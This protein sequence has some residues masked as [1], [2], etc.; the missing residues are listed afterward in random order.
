MCVWLTVFC[1]SITG[2]LT[3]CVRAC[4]R[5]CTCICVWFT[6]VCN[7]IFSECVSLSVSLCL[8]VYLTSVTLSICVFVCLSD[9]LPVCLYLPTYVY[10]LFMSGLLVCTCIGVLNLRLPSRFNRHS[11]VLWYSCSRITFPCFGFISEVTDTTRRYI[12]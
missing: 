11:M 3:L 9:C 12:L 2:C 1:M 10:V 4:M 8:C 6:S 7:S 5:V